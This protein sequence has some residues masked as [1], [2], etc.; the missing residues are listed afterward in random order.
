M[1]LLAGPLF[2]LFVS[3]LRMRLRATDASGWA[4]VAFGCGIV[5]SAALGMVAV[6]RGVISRSVSVDDEPLPG[7]DTLR[8]ATSL[9]FH[10]WDVVILFAVVL[11]AVVSAHALAT[12]ALPRWLGWLGVPVALGSAVMLA[13]QSSAFSL[14]LLI[15][16]VLAGSV[17]LLRTPSGELASEPSRRPEAA[18][19]NA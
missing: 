10:V 3:R 12:R 18:S 5:M 15:I 7:V 8:F 13:V 14:P 2:L 4:D 6:L 19:V 11:V 16:W 9:A 1:L 17:H